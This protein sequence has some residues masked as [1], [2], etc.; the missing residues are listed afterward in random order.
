ME[1]FKTLLLSNVDFTCTFACKEANFVV[2]HLAKHA[3]SIDDFEAWFE[4]AP[5]WLLPYLR[6]DYHSLCVFRMNLF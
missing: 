5:E 6:T 2:H 4:E 1:N 3:F